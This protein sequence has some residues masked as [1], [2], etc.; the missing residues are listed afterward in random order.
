MYKNPDYW[1]ADQAVRLAY[2]GVRKNKCN[3]HYD[4]LVKI[5]IKAERFLEAHE[6]M[7]RWERLYMR[8]HNNYDRLSLPKRFVKIRKQIEA[9]L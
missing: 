3:A 8:D 6:Q 4:T 9:N 7:S 2:A 1:D 5:L